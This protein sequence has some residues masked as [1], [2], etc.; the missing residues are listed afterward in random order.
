MLEIIAQ[1]WL[2]FLLGLI[3]GGLVLLCKKL[4][5]M[6]QNEKN[7]QKT[8]EQKQF[9]QGIQDAIKQGSEDA[10][11]GD[12]ILQ[13]QIDIIMSG[14]L[15]IQGRAFKQECRTLLKDGHEITLE[16]WESIQE[17]HDIYNALGGN[18]DGDSLFKMVEHKA[19]K[20]LSD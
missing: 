5:K 9:Y 19:M 11:H 18:H 8:E 20:N 2:N 16:E 6:Y 14:V 17:E 15:S 1:Y 13:K 3:S 12:E 10:K 7:H 4:W